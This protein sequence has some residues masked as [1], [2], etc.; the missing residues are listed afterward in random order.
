MLPLYVAAVLEA[1]IGIRFRASHSLGEWA[2]RLSKG[3]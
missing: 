1:H 3:F 2:L